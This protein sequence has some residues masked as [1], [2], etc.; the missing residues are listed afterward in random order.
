MGNGS[1]FDAESPRMPHGDGEIQR[2]PKLLM[3]I[4]LSACSEGTPGIY[5]APPGA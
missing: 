1:V 5:R 2:A 3:G 4:E